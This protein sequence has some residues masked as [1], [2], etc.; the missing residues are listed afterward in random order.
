MDVYVLQHSREYDDTEDIKLIGVYSSE[1]AARAAIERLL[2]Q[3]G[4]RSYPDGFHV[5]RYPLDKDH[6]TE[7]FGDPSEV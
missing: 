7:G 6:W 3:P 2:R 5:D 4:F 1:A